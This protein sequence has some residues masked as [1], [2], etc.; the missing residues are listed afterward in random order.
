MSIATGPISSHAIVGTPKILSIS[1]PKQVGLGASFT[2]SVSAAGSAPL[3]FQWFLGGTPVEGG[4]L[5]NLT[6]RASEATVGNYTVVVSNRFAQVVSSNYPVAIGPAPTIVLNPA[7]QTKLFGD[8]VTFGV[9]VS[10][11]SPYF[12]QWYQNA[13]ARTG[14]ISATLI[15]TNLTSAERGLWSVAVSNGFGVT[16]SQSAELVVGKPGRFDSSFSAI[17]G[18]ADGLS[19]QL[20]VEP[21]AIYRLQSS[22]NL[23]NWTNEKAFSIGNNLYEEMIPNA[24][25]SRRFYRVISP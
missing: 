12:Y 20:A 4:T 13:L 19:F 17:V 6:A 16:F 24:S 14:A 1:G 10:G 2:L 22:S 25:N 8:S 3:E 11:P 18:G 15:V 21:D 7:S 5:S 23:V 9:T